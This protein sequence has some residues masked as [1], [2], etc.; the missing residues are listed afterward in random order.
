MNISPAKAVAPKTT[1]MIRS[2]QDNAMLRLDSKRIPLPMPDRAESM[3][4]SVS[5]VT[6]IERA[7]KLGLPSFTS[8]DQLV[9]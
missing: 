2:N 1:K 8:H 9:I 6:A 5:K 3:A 7:D 4:A